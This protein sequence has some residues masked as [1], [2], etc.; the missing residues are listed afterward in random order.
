[1]V[2]AALTIAFYGLPPPQQQQEV[3]TY[4]P[5]TGTNLNGTLS[6]LLS[7][8]NTSSGSFNLS[9]GASGKV[10]AELYDV[11][12]C[13]APTANCPLSHRVATWS[14]STSGTYQFSG[15]VVYPYLLVWTDRAPR[16]VDFWASSLAQQSV[17]GSFPVVMVILIDVAVI[18][19]ATTG[20]LALFLGGFLRAGYRPP[21]RPEPP[22]ARRRPSMAAGRVTAP[23]MDSPDDGVGSL[24]PGPPALMD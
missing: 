20:T 13:P 6:V 9:W 16:T 24:H 14:G 22:V 10:D 3:T 19:L 2:A 7:G 4:V 15:P 8:S 21:R 23:R 12:G 18:S 5:A 17:P 11:P 1:V